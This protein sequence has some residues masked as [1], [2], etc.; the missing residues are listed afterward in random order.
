MLARKAILAS[1]FL[2]AALCT[3]EPSHPWE[4]RSN[5]LQPIDAGK[6]D[7]NQLSTSNFVLPV[8]LRLPTR[9]E[10]VYRLSDVLRRGTNWN[11]SPDLA[12]RQAN[13]QDGFVRFSGGVAAVFNFS[14]YTATSRGRITEIPEGTVFHLDL[15]PPGPS[16]IFYSTPGAV[17][18]NTVSLDRG[19]ATRNLATDGVS[20]QPK[21]IPADVPKSEEVARSLWTDELYRGRT[22]TELLDQTALTARP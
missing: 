4:V 14:R 5:M 15:R 18:Y 1:V 7:I 2:P 6:A 9:F 19:A 20:K 11:L 21:I 12:R 17:S 8:D 13:N 16:D 3:A 10:R 22:V